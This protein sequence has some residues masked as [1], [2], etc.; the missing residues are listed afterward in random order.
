MKNVAVTG[1]VPENVNEILNAYVQNNPTFNKSSV[2]GIA[3]EKFLKPDADTGNEFVEQ[4]KQELNEAQSF[5]AA[6]EA[7]LLQQ[8]ELI[9][10]L[11][12]QVQTLQT[13]IENH[14]PGVELQENQIIVTVPNTIQPFL[15]ELVQIES[16]RTNRTIKPADLLLQL[17][18]KQIK[19]GAGDHLPKSYSDSQIRAKL[20][21]VLEQIKAN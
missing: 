15:D 8:N 7:Q 17:F 13:E 19:D 14:Q 1:K 6:N 21:Q 20:Q 18:W 10:T 3:V 2:V 11:Q 5:A 4:L 9:E 16:R 12:T